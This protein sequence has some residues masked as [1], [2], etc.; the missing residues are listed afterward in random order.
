MALVPP[1]PNS[2]NVHKGCAIDGA[3]WHIRS[4]RK[5]SSRKSKP[6][7]LNQLACAIVD[8]ATDESTRKEEPSDKACYQKNFAVVCIFQPRDHRLFGANAFGL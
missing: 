2:A 8:E 5:R 4:L 6:T 3:L 1:S 7:D